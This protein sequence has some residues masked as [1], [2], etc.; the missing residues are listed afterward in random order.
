MVFG[1]AGGVAL[2]VATGMA[3]GVAFVA[4]FT[5]I[6]FYPLEGMLQ[7]TIY[8]H[9]LTSGR[10]TLQ[11]APVLFHDLSYVP[12]PFLA[13]HI[14]DSAP[15][16]PE[17]TRRVVDACALVPGQK[18]IALYVLQKLQTRELDD[19]GRDRD[20]AEVAHLR[21]Q[22]LPGSEGADP[23]LLAFRDVARYIRA[24]QT[25]TQ[26]YHRLTHLVRAERDLDALKSRLVT[27]RSQWS[28][29]LP[30]VV[31]TWRD[32]VRTMRGE[33]EVA[34]V[35]IIP[36]PFRAGDPLEPSD[37]QELF[38]GR[39]EI[40]RTIENLL[41]DPLQS[42]SIAVLGPRR[43][44][45]TSLLKML[46][47]ML[48][49]TLCVLFDIQDNPTNLPARF[50]AALAERAAEQARKDGARIPPLLTP[51]RSRGPANGFEIWTSYEAADAFCFAW[52]S[53]S[54]WRIYGPVIGVV[55]SS[56]W[57]CSVALSSIAATSGSSYPALRRSTSWGHFGT[58]TLSTYVW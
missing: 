18:R 38:R 43:C 6:I 40:I 23:L 26:P 15:K 42:A 14:I 56:S 11:F 49:D 44:G 32:A 46:P 4:S 5:R 7:A 9:Q 58:I 28:Q 29:L 12:H 34:A 37:G 22:W 52:T 13:G 31:E 54:G 2:G 35:S 36:N 51:R 1:V 39:D 27:E 10:V 55:C 53:S 8:F 16:A 25:V 19:A 24:A 50:F 30:P 47:S 17:L 45:K 57:G 21:G 33:A 20:F 3:F 48:P 41:A